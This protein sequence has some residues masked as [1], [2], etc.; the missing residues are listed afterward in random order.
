MIGI[1]LFCDSLK[2]SCQ[3]WVCQFSVAMALLRNEEPSRYLTPSIWGREKRCARL[4]ISSKVALPEWWSLPIEWQKFHQFTFFLRWVTLVK[5]HARN[6]SWN[7]ADSS[8]KAYNS[9]VI[10]L[11]N[12]LNF[13]RWDFF[14]KS[15]N[16]IFS[17]WRGPHNGSN[18]TSH[19]LSHP[20]FFISF[21]V[22]CRR[23]AQQKRPLRCLAKH[24]IRNARKSQEILLK[25]KKSALSSLKFLSFFKRRGPS[26]VPWLTHFE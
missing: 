18:F 23:W 2:H 20:F 12:C 1:W 16:F 24:R 3:Q 22:S 6:A 13:K 14:F 25:E 15:V 10:C 26:F 19:I 4:L 21:W 11:K 9:R 7:V 17:S 8:S 5:F